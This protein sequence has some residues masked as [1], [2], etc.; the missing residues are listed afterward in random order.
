MENLRLGVSA[1]RH[2]MRRE[3]TVEEAEKN[4]ELGRQTPKA[5]N[6]ITQLLFYFYVS[7]K[8]IFSSLKI[9]SSISFKLNKKILLFL[10]FFSSCFHFQLNNDTHKQHLHHNLLFFHS[11]NK[12]FFQYLNV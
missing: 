8:F 3:D 1:V 12:A 5:F 10:T 6:F 7:F 9:L 2:D 11:V 4:T